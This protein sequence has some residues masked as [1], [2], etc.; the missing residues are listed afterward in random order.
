MNMNYKAIQI[1]S[2]NI[3]EVNGIVTGYGSIFGNVDSDGDIMA[4]GCYTKTLQENGSRVKYCWQHDIWQPIGSFNS[5]VEDETG[6]KFEA[7]IPPTR[8]GKDA[9]ILMKNGVINE[10]SVGFGIVK[11]DY[12]S[13]GIRIIREVK[14]YEISCVTLAANPLALI[15][16][17]KGEAKFEAISAK[18]DN[19]NK[20]LKKQDISD[21]LGYALE[22][23][24]LKLKAMVN[25]M[26]TLPSVEDTKSE[27]PKVELSEV[28]KYLN[29]NFNK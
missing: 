14:L 24:L 20:V 12:N 23:D 19:I 1:D 16:D 17:A 11:A 28:F 9:L 8:L 21:E 13:D 25:A 29:T 7:V 2:Q 22:A 3:D 15:T 4:K 18:I 5:L 27:E 26:S 6:L 10:N